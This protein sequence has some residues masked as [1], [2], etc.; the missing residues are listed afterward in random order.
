MPYADRDQQRRFQREWARRRRA[1]FFEAKSC[2]WCG[3]TGDLHLHHRDRSKKVSHK[4]WSWAPARL[5]AEASKC[6]ILCESCHKRA[7]ADERRITAELRN[8]HGTVNRY[9]MGCRCEDCRAGNRDRQR[10]RK[11][12]A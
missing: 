12:A 11:R 8:P 1:A 5:A 10:E 4:I 3:A 6:L 2:E 9:K 7:H